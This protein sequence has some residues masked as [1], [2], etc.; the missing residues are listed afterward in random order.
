M[1]AIIAAEALR[2]IAADEGE[3]T[4]ALYAKWGHGIE[5][6]ANVMELRLALHEYRRK[7][8][9][10]HWRLYAPHMAQC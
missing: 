8:G 5:G 9:P 4:I 3:E 2:R 6:T 7:H 10:D 1:S